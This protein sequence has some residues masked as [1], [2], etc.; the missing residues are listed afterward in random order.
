MK[1][2]LYFA[3]FLLAVL[4]CTA[5]QVPLETSFLRPPATIQTSVYWYWMSGNISREGVIKD[6]E[7]MKKA[8]INR[9]FIGNIYDEPFEAGR[10]V[11]LLSEEWWDITHTALKKAGELDIEIGIFNS[12]GWSQS[13]GP[14]NKDEQSMRYLTASEL[15]LQGPATIDTF[16]QRP[17]EKFQDVKL[18]AYPA[19]AV[20]LLMLDASNAT[21]NVS[22]ALTNHSALFDKNRE[23]GMRLPKDTTVTITLTA[24]AAFTA[25]SITI[26]PLHSLIHAGFE[27]QAWINGSYQKISEFTIDWHNLASNVGFQPFAPTAIS[28]PE[29]TA[30]A[31]RIIATNRSAH[32]GIAEI[33]LSAAPRIENYAQKTF[34][35]MFQDPMPQWDYYMWRPQPELT[36]PSLV[37]DPA[38]V[39]D[40]TRHMSA[41]GR[42]K[43]SVPAGKW[44]IMRTGMTPTGVTNSPAGPDGTGPE[45]DKMNKKHVAA[46]FDAFIGKIL[47]RIPSEDRKTFRIVVQ[48]SYE[49]GGQNFTDE[50]L[51]SFKKQY[52]YDALPY[53]PA[54]LGQVVG[55]QQQ[56]DKFLWD[57]RR[58]VADQVAY[59]YVAGFREKCHE[60]GLRTWLENYGHWG[61]PA[62]FLQYGGQS[63]EV[64]GEFWVEND[65]GNIENRAASSCAHIYGKNLVSAESN[66]SG[67]PTFS[68]SPRDTKKR[69]DKFFAEGINNTLLHVYI[70]QP[71]NDRYPGTNAWFGTEYT[72]TNT[73]FS[74][75]DLYT[76]YIKRCNLLLQQGLNIADIAYFIGEDVPK[77]TGI[78]DPALPAGYQ[79]DYI[80]AEVLLRDAFVKNGR[81]T[82]PHGTSY[83]ILV[84]PKID[85]MRPELLAKL[86]TLVQ[87]GAILLGSKPTHSPSLQNQPK[88][89]ALVQE[90]ANEIWH[91]TT[92]KGKVFEGVTLQEVFSSIGE[93]PDC[94]IPAENPINFIH[95]SMDGAE[96]YFLTNQSPTKQE[97]L[98]KFRVKDLQPELWNAINGGTRLLPEYTSL[99]TG[100]EVP[101]KLDGFE[102]AFIVFRKPG[103]PNKGA[104]NYST[105]TREIALNQPWLL[106]F[107][108]P[109][110][111][112]APLQLSELQDLSHF[113]NEKIKYF[114]GTMVYQTQFTLNNSAKEDVYLD[115][116][117]V[118]H[119]AKVWLNGQYLGGAW[120]LP[121]R[122][123]LT[124]ALK[125]GKNELKVEVVN[126][127][128]NRL[129]GDKIVAEKD[130]ET[131]TRINPYNEKS[132]LQPSGLIGP[133]RLLFVH[134]NQIIH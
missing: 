98:I 32:G 27:V 97:A 14:W 63:D 128:A 18:I 16:L 52:G 111:K 81:I 101:I 129:I 50:F 41:D 93:I 15:R 29:T 48:D 106:Q 22:P 7:A 96:I 75:L 73:W 122:I 40:L 109:L 91:S 61:F 79:F 13:G 8:G 67:G 95:R 134:R 9:A 107:E 6:L 124:D 2:L 23:Q 110:S 65:L 82:L 55:S 24:K 126:N 47:Q 37:I 78:Q 103:K 45:V 12:P 105:P 118:Q 99:A 116:G 30:S 133:A 5:Q 20:D 3:T 66:T 131:W 100:T 69:M 38:R 125:K 92:A 43:W 34:A 64:A 39:L 94:S 108:S 114:S 127:W 72:R 130:R 60:H 119:M 84:L 123:K 11:K 83:R 36:N 19:S 71:E 85:N 46:H 76:D 59:E 77:M 89:D 117:N 132:N 70:Q 1:R 53:L 80:N 90:L 10:N 4:F 120:T 51:T 49:T 35:K 88:A 54:Y 62:E 74:Q 87:D 115:L 58:H 57:V 21:I 56:S 42:L 31:F 113:D 68:R 44:V 33:E 26:Y 17:N 28:F 86:K 112:P 25:R 121:Y 102:S 104:T